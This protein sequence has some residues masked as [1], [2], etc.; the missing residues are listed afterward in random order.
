MKKVSNQ[1]MLITYADSMGDDLKD[2]YEILEE[3]FDGVFGGVHLLPIFPS[4]GDRGYAPLHYTEVDPAFGT[5]DDIKKFSENF[6]LMCDFMINHLSV[7][8][9]E[10]LDYLKNKD[11]SPYRDMFIRWS[12]FWPNGEPSDEDLKAMY[13]RKPEGP[14]KDFTFEDGST[15]KLWNTFGPEQIDVNPWSPATQEFYRRSLAQLAQYFSIIRYDAVAYATKKPGTNCFFLEPDIWELFRMGTEQIKPLGAE[16]LPEIH[17][18]YKLQLRMAEQGYWVY[19]F[20]LPMLLLHGMM[21]GRADRLIRWLKIC[22]KK[23]FTTLDTHDGI[24]VVDVGDLLEDDDI[25]MVR[26]RVSE[27]LSKADENLSI[28]FSMIKQAGMEKL[29][30]LNCTWYS[31]LDE[32]DDAYLLSRIVQLYTP[33]IPQIYYVGLLAGKNDIEAVK[34]SGER[35]DINRHPYSREEITESVQKPILKRMLQIMRFRNTYP[36]FDGDLS[37]TEHVNPSI[38]D[39]YWSKDE[40][41]THL[42]ADFITKQ[43]TISYY[44][45]N[46]GETVCL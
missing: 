34:E 29:Y 39:V 4:S 10:F 46:T 36:A 37:I 23:Q 12:E 38:L 1:T 3:H 35:R 33:G 15:V 2:L 32:D 26:D 44:D 45:K 14:V 6:F 11:S 16:I 17:E 8:S 9:K 24:G 28:P 27:L 21:A 19:D 42:L 18:D 25:N 30:Q 7:R 22:P 5:W 13:F 40:Y 41:T 20:A 43:Y 31:A